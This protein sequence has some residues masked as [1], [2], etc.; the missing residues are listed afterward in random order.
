MHEGGRDA[1]AGAEV[2]HGVDWVCGAVGAAG[3]VD[4]VVGGAVLRG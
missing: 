1:G 3:G 2:P 4:P